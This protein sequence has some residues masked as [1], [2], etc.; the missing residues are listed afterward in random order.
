MMHLTRMEQQFPETHTEHRNRQFVIDVSGNTN[1][2]SAK[3][4]L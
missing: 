4:F 3:I 2:G 1:K